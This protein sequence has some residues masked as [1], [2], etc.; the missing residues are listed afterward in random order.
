MEAANTRF[1]QLLEG[2]PQGLSWMTIGGVSNTGTVTDDSKTTFNY[3][4]DFADVLMKKHGKYALQSETHHYAVVQSNLAKVGAMIMVGGTDDKRDSLAFLLHPTMAELW[5]ATFEGL[6]HD[7]TRNVEMHILP[8][9][10]ATQDVS[11][12]DD[13]LKEVSRYYKTVMEP[14][15]ATRAFFDNNS[16]YAI[17]TLKTYNSD[18]SDK[19]LSE[20]IAYHVCKMIV[21]K[22]TG[23]GNHALDIRDIAVASVE[24]NKQKNEQKVQRIKNMLSLRGRTY[25]GIYV[26]PIPISSTR[27][28]YSSSTKGSRY[29]AAEKFA[30][31][32]L[33][34]RQTEIDCAYGDCKPIPGMAVPTGAFINKKFDL[35]RPTVINPNDINCSI[36]TRQEL[37]KLAKDISIDLDPEE[38]D[39]ALC[40]RIKKTA[41]RM[42]RGGK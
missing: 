17:V 30:A 11:F 28:T 4:N 24:T 10:V 14:K 41:A 5:R 34:K 29:G 20:N 21:E 8:A 19:L 15:D 33:K 22:I 31:D 13:L 40:G 23:T 6:G 16:G 32:E 39:E 36:Y 3:S 37:D 9:S 25:P 42:Y 18:H 38:S 35:P 12:A 2:K 7:V 27:L 1:R 26:E